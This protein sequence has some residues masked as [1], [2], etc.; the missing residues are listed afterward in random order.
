[1]DV[2]GPVVDEKKGGS[3]D[4]A[5][6]KVP[7]DGPILESSAPLVDLQKAALSDNVGDVF[8]DARAI[9]LGKDG[10]ERPIGMCNYTI[11]LSF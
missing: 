1:M 7:F 6:E 8:D 2:D 5:S 4:F 3:V 10:K 11:Y 9:D